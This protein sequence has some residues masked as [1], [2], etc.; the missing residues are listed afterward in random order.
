MVISNDLTADGPLDTA[1]VREEFERLGRH[2]DDKALAS[3]MT[4]YLSQP[5]SD[6]ETAWAYKSLANAFAVGERSAEA[7]SLMNH[8][9][10][11]CPTSLRACRP[12]FPTIRRRT[13][14]QRRLWARTRSA[15]TFSDNL[16]SLRPHTPRSAAMRTSWP[17]L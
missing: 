6:S 17:R 13:A 15:C 4:R 10:A 8:S 7:C 1:T 12:S 11:G 14:P 16:P 2:W 3:L 9:S 5:L